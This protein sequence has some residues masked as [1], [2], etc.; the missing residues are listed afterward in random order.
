MKKVALGLLVVV[1]ISSFG[2]INSA[3]AEDDKVAG[4]LKEAL[5]VGI[6]NAVKSVGIED[7]FYKNLDIKVL[8]PDKLKAADEALKGLGLGDLS[9]ELIKKMNRAAELA[10]PKANDIFVDAIKQLSFTDAMQIL[11]GKESEATEFL[12]KTASEPL[13]AAFLPI[14]KSSMEEV[15][16]LKAFND[17][18]DKY[19]SNP[20]AE[21]IDVDINQHVTDKAIDGLFKMIAVEEAKIRKDPAARTSDLLNEIFGGL[22]K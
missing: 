11:Q 4:G 10:A 8:L 9:E 2:F 13:N 17:F 15:K 22:S 14:I 21:K 12:K 7:G 3:A 18:M 19:S 16:A 1:A 6:Q 20:L 5:T